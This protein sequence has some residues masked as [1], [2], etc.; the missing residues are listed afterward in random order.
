ME[1]TLTNLKRYCL[2]NYGVV[3]Q[4]PFIK[5]MTTFR[6]ISHNVSACE[7]EPVIE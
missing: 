4:D 2:E 1:M 7:I 6:K 3:I 5:K